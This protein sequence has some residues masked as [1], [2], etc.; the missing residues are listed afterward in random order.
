MFWPPLW[1]SHFW[2]LG[3]NKASYSHTVGW[4]VVTSWVV[5]FWR[6]D[7]DHPRSAMH[8]VFGPSLGQTRFAEWDGPL[9]FGKMLFVASQPASDDRWLTAAFVFSNC[10]RFLKTANDSAHLL[11]FRLLINDRRTSSLYSQKWNRQ[12]QKKGHFRGFWLCRR[13]DLINAH[14]PV[15]SWS[16]RGKTSK[17]MFAR[18]KIKCGTTEGKC[19][20]WV[21]ISTF[22]GA[23]CFWR[24]ICLQNWSCGLF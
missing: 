2:V 16:S 13:S 17:E 14:L 23:K 20:V 11:C 8:A 1:V 15:N 22:S 12:P 9:C 24:Y 7:L 6:Q 18:L 3:Q 19:R 4:D 21:G 10:F 5:V